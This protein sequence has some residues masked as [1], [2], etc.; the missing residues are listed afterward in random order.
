MPPSVNAWTRLDPV[1][2]SQALGAGLNAEVRDPLWMLTRQWQLGELWGEDVGSPV[3]TWLELDCVPLTRYLPGGIAPGATVAGQDVVAGTPLETLVEREPV[4]VDGAQ[5]LRLA[6]EAG[7]QFRRM[8]VDAGAATLWPGVVQ[9]FQ[10]PAPG[11]DV[12]AGLEPDV[13]R[14]LEIVAGRVA[15][16]NLLAA[17][18][19]GLTATGALPAAVASGVATW[20]TW[21]SSLPEADRGRLDTAAG[22]WLTW[23]EALFSEPRP[24]TANPAWVPERLEYALAVSTVLPERQ[25]L[26]KIEFATGEQPPRYAFDAVPRTE[27]V[28][29]APEYSAGHLDWYSF[30]ALPTGSLGAPAVARDPLRR[31]AIPTAAR[32]PGMPASRYWEFEDAR[33]DFGAVAAGPQQLAH[34]LLVEFALIHADDWFVIPVDVP[35]GTVSRVRWLVVADTFGQR[36]IIPSAREVDRAAGEQQLPWD[37]FRL[38]PDPGVI[39]ASAV[40]LTDV[41][42]LPPSLG[43][44]LHGEPVEEVA[45]LRDSMANMAWAVERLVEGLIGQPVDLSEAFHRARVEEPDEASSVAATNG[46]PPLM[47]RLSTPVPRHWLPL[48]PARI[49]ADAPD[50]WLLRG[51]DPRGRIMEPERDPARRPLYVHEEELPLEGARVTRA[52]QYARWVD[53]STHLWMGRRK[54][55]G[56]RGELSSG[57]RFDVLE[58][59]TP[60]SGS[61]QIGA[62]STVGEDTLLRRLFG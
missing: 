43:L 44:S 16:G 56:R 47:Y 50:M 4:R 25:I 13:L 57:L 37:M 48:Y 1:I 34:L 26:R 21:R 14:F 53:G 11:A 3:Q 15:D 22:T 49:R 31:T 6:A 20:R 39:G 40:A 17:V 7:L 23:Y 29:S 5:Q 45:L 18:V 54:S 36:T 46:Q 52:Y 51:G 58:P 30:G 19:R 35:V 61:M 8:L 33:V 24:A 42:F 9:H 41:L 32:F 12:A 59:A 27:L 10:I 28:L 55:V 38:A 62:R 2:Q 60:L